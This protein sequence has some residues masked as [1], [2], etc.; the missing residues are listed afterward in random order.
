MTDLPE[1]PEMRLCD[2][3]RSHTIALESVL[4]GKGPAKEKTK[5]I[6]HRCRGFLQC[7]ESLIIEMEVRENESQRAAK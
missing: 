6:M 2:V 1:T 5:T 7:L 3:T 4:W